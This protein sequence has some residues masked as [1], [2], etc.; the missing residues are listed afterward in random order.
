MA[1]LEAQITILEKNNVIIA[2]EKQE[3]EQKMSK[4]IQDLQSEIGHE[5]KRNLGIK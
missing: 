3:Y 1:D 2:E 4:T 5:K